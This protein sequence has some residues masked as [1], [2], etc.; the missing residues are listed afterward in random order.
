V[1]T[2]KQFERRLTQLAIACALALTAGACAARLPDLQSEGRGYAST[3][4]PLVAAAAGSAPGRP[5]ERDQALEGGSDAARAGVDLYIEWHFTALREPGAP[6]H[7]RV[8]SPG[9]WEEKSCSWLLH[10]RSRRR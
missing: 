6:A 4:A 1:T 5:G 8:A 10:G 3:P 2:N 9:R 7:R